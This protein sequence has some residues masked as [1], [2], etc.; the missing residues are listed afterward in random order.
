MIRDAV[1]ADADGLGALHVRSWQATYRDQLPSDFLSGLDVGARVKWFQRHISGGATVLVAEDDGDV[2]GFASI[3]ASRESDGGEVYAIYVDPAHWGRG[4]GHRLLSEA[5][6]K[7]CEMSF[8]WAVLWVL[9]AN[10]RAR[11]FYER[12]SWKATGALKLEDIGGTQV[13]EVRYEKT[14]QNGI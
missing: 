5:E 6:S 9:Q 4:H 2:V 1:L 11:R 10:E 12:Q 3:G 14:L 13:T 7:L 8:R